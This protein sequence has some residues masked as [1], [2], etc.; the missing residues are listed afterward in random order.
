MN[1]KTAIYTNN[2]TVGSYTDIGKSDTYNT[3]SLGT[4]YTISNGMSLTR[5]ISNTTSN[6]KVSGVTDV[7]RLNLE[8]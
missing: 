5:D 4:K 1:G 7:T 6:N 2:G 8:F 3:V